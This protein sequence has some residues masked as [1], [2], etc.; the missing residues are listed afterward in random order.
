MGILTYQSEYK[1]GFLPSAILVFLAISSSS[2]LPLDPSQ[3]QQLIQQLQLQFPSSGGIT[4]EIPLPQF[5]QSLLTP[6]GRSDLQPLVEENLNENITTILKACYNNGYYYSRPSTTNPVHNALAIG[7]LGLGAGVLGSLLLGGVLGRSNMED[8]LANL[9]S[10]PVTGR[11]LDA[12]QLPI[13][14]VLQNIVQ[15]VQSGNSIDSSSLPPFLTAFINQLQTGTLP[16]LLQNLV[17]LIQS[18]SSQQAA[19]RSDDVAT[20]IEDIKSAED[21]LKACYSSNYSSGYSSYPY[22]SSYSSYPAYSYP[23]SLYTGGLTAGTG[24]PNIAISPITGTGGVYPYN[25]Y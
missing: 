12:S 22:S 16:P 14:P 9:P 2:A 21:L 23:G 1:M 24:Y 15:Q 25:P 19:G 18:S 13:P 8:I 17:S 20:D 3:L 7:G 5:F 11:A 10:S 4:A 6:S